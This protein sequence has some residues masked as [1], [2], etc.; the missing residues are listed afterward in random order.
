L[1]EYNEIKGNTMP[2]PT[3]FHSRTSALCESREWRTWSGYLSA[4]L[5]EPTFEREYFAIRNSAAM[6]DVSPLFKYEISGP[7]AARVV[8]RII[9]RDVSK[10]HVG[11]VL[12]SPW[13]DEEGKVIDDGI[14][15]RLDENTFRITAADPNL[16]WFQDV[17]YGF[18][19]QVRDVSTE[20]AALSLQGPNSR[21]I[22]KEAAS[23]IDFERLNYS[24][25]ARGRIHNFPVTVTRTGYTGDLGYELWVDPAHAGSLWDRLLEAG[26]QYGI[27][28]AGMVALDIARIEAGLLLIEV[29]YI[30]SRHAR[31]EAQK[32]SPFEL[33]LGWA[34]ALD[35]GS[36][37]GQ[38]AL[39]AEKV[40]GSPW[41]FIGVAIDWVDLE[42]LFHKVNLPP[43]VTGRASR[44]AVP[45]Y[46]NGKQIGQ[47]TSSTFSPLLKKYIGLGTVLSA[48]ATAGTQ[49]EIE[50]TVE[51]SR[52]RGQATIV[53]TP[54]I[55]PARKRM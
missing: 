29:D 21:T 20:L 23:G 53:K 5:Y 16:N 24:W 48:Y 50:I 3:P 41:A 42:R 30:S 47:I 11:Q 34:V 39:R 19:A 38:K 46:K 51:Y 15:A 35:G 32:S 4:G 33:G 13:C 27:L 26:S 54:F 9:T 2:I 55:D 40:H 28:P 7:D 36:F 14:V 17:G 6:I 45:L 22:L 25:L 10:C 52:E 49:V 8:D 1:T 12:Y 37:I 31:I 43:Q 44:T 18:D